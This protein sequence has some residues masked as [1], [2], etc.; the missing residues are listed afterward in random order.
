M[1]Q[2][3]SGGARLLARARSHFSLSPHAR[4]AGGASL[5]HRGRH[6]GTARALLPHLMPAPTARLPPSRASQ[7]RVLLGVALA[8]AFTAL[9]FFNRG[10]REREERVAQMRDASYA[11]DEARSARLSVKKAA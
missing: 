2:R 3:R 7:P 1:R 11:K 6:S 4:Q 8:L 10:V 9:P 5:L